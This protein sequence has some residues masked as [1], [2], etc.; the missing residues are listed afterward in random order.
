MNFQEST[1]ILKADTKK[2]WKPIEGTAYVCFF[3]TYFVDSKILIF[4]SLAES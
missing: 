4:S 2:V 3:C 1:T